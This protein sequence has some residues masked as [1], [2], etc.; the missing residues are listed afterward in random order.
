[1]DFAASG[2]SNNPLSTFTDSV[3]DTGTY[4]KGVCG[5]KNIATAAGSPA[6]ASVA[7]GGDKINDDFT[8]TVDNSLTTDGDIGS[9]TLTLEISS[10]LYPADVSM[11]TNTVT[12]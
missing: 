1:M 9:H 6:W 3:D 4:T 11:V 7:Q 5:T 8:L 10:D 12:V 2:L